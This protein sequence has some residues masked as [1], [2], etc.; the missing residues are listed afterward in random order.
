MWSPS[1]PFFSKGGALRDISKTAAKKTIFL[2]ATQNDQD[3]WEYKGSRGSK[4]YAE[5]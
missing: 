2:Y 3:F 4:R 1:Q 5:K